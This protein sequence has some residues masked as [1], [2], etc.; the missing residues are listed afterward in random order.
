MAGNEKKESKKR[1]VRWN[2]PTPHRLG[3]KIV[4]EPGENLVDEAEL[5]AAY[6][7]P[8]VKLHVQEGRLVDVESERRRSLS[9]A[10]LKADAEAKAKAREEEEAAVARAKAEAEKRE[11]ESK[12]TERTGPPEQLPTI[13]P[14]QPAGGKPQNP[15]DHRRG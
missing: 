1:L 11:A 7:I 14:A 13:P 12:T 3:R 9:D 2:G 8:L 10:E 4:L 6:E 5:L 15:K